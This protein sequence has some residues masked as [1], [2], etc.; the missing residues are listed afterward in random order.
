M[1]YSFLF[2]LS[3]LF[4]FNQLFAQLPIYNMTN[5]TVDD[6]KG[7]LLDSEDGSVGGHYDHDEN[8]TFSICLP[9]NGTV[10]LIFS[11]FCTEVNY[12]SLRIFDGPDTLSPQIGPAYM[13][14]N[15]PGTV[16]STGPCL[17]VNFI[18]DANVSC[19]GWTA[20]WTTDV[21]APVLPPMAV[22]NA[23]PP[24]STNTVTVSFSTP[25]ACDSLDLS[26]FQL[27]GPAGTLTS[28]TPLNCVNG[29]ATQ[30]Q[31]GMNPGANASG[32]YQVSY[33]SAFLDA[34]D[35]L[36]ILTTTDTFL[37]NDCPLEMYL[38]ADPDTIC[39]G[40]C[41][42][43]TAMVSGGDFQTYGYSWTP[44]FGNSPGPFT[45]CPDST[46]T[47]YLTVSDGAGSPPVTDSVTV[48]VLP[49]PVAPADTALCQSDP[50]FT[51]TGTPS[52][53]SWSGPGII[54]PIAGL[55]EPDSAGGGIHEVIYTDS[56][57]C[58]DSLLVD[59]TEIDPGP[60]QAACPAT[61]PFG[62]VGFSPIGGVWSGPNISA[63]GV[64]TPPATI[65]T[66]TVTYTINGCIAT[67]D[68]Y[69]DYPLITLPD[70]ICQSEDDFNLSASPPGGTWSGPGVEDSLTGYFDPGSANP[71]DNMLIYRLSGCADTFN[72]FIKEINFPWD[73]AACPQQAPYSLGPGNPPGG[74]WGSALGG[75]VD[76]I[77][78]IFDPGIM[79]GANFTDTV[80]YSFDGC[81]RTR[82][83]YVIQTEIDYDTVYRCMNEGE[84]DLNYS[85]TRRRPW[86]GDWSGPG[87]ID[88][89][90]PGIFDPA[91]AGPGTHLL[92]YEA[93]TCSDSLYL[94]VYPPAVYGDSS[95]CEIT[96]PFVIPSPSPGGRWD[97]PGITNQN[98][99]IFDP[100]D[101]GVGVH[102]LFY[103]SPFGCIDSIEMEVTALPQVNIL[104]LASQYCFVDSAYVLTGLPAGGT[105]SGPGIVG[106]TF[107][108]A[109][110]GA[111]GPYLIAYTAGTGECQRTATAITGVSPPISVEVSISADTICPGEVIELS[112]T[113]SGGGTGIF[114]YLW[115]PINR[116]Q[117][118]VS[119]A[120]P[121]STSYAVRV[122][123][124][125]SDAV[126]ESL[127][128]YV[129]PDY[130]LSFT[131]SDPV[132]F[133]EEGW[134]A[135]QITGPNTYDIFWDVNPPQSGD[136]LRG[137]TDFNY[138]AI[139][140]DLNTG[141]E[142]SGLTEI[143]RWPYVE[144]Q[145][146]PNPNDYCASIADPVIQMVDQSVGG[147][148][149]YWDFGDG[150]QQDYVLGQDINHRYP[151]IGDYTINLY[152][153]NEGGCSDTISASICI[154]PLQSYV[155][156]PNAFT[157]NADNVNDQ[158]V[159]VAQGFEA[160]QLRIFDRWGK[161]VFETQDPN[162]T[163]DGT[164][165]GKGVPEGTYVWKIE[166]QLV[167]NNPD[168]DY[169]ATYFR[170]QGSVTIYR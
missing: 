147:F 77:N 128:V 5:L 146:L 59:I 105:F 28:A 11:D 100:Q 75:I 123:D 101:A 80:F 65:G 79:M 106:N 140:T 57:G 109:L 29:F 12:D 124:G 14:T 24:C 81:T 35:S 49:N 62:M 38:E 150:T 17:T 37:V 58:S 170:D 46:T 1:R 141:C 8:Y 33:T 121:N 154:E 159:V 160:Y 89:D 85:N 66:F 114:N 40:G 63:T 71:G 76:S 48:Y 155:W 169:R 54:D 2:L 19:T 41:A 162:A 51:L 98:H 10:T 136:T 82:E 118:T 166:G 134:S 31:L 44:A 72:L 104:D 34:C 122:S 15:N 84:M 91:V 87:V 113:A 68:I 92:I 18:S 102:T 149:G 47:Y 111:G 131:S 60:V 107:N 157:P 45:V 143:P 148:S 95:V 117:S 156:V 83:I 20:Q 86:D 125:C 56:L 163:W 6:C 3:L 69:I 42:D 110:A 108:P 7:F 164:Y 115:Q 30:V 73:N 132:C 97:G 88:P 78:G 153:E 22:Q 4:S 116:T 36:W 32:L 127:S 21:E 112:A 167:R 119:I 67:K 16:T 138:E 50:A 168:I 152:I 135:I 25:L 161:Q 23:A 133:G 70:T 120:P 26:S 137:P 9:G 93:N 74:I 55:F 52:G 99:G 144:A 43:L 151:T 13:G 129:H 94:T 130:S 165:Q 145:F 158:F 139:V 27:S 53:G 103:T 96:T 61:A 64:F 39:F 142:K 90:N 126:T